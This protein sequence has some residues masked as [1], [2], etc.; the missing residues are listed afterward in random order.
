MEKVTWRVA[1]PGSP[2]L[3]RDEPTN[4]HC[5]GLLLA[6]KIWWPKSVALHSTSVQTRA[7]KKNAIGHHGVN[8]AFKKTEQG[9]I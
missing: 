8:T 9:Q 2:G 5:E 4:I 6:A 7:P 1:K 3:I